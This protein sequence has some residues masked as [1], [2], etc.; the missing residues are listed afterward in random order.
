MKVLLSAFNTKDVENFGDYEGK[1]LD[2]RL[3]PNIGD[4]LSFD[5]DLT[6]KV[7]AREFI[8]IKGKLETIEIFCNLE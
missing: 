2:N 6:V 8:Y 1:E 5:E 4:H 7:A 3:I